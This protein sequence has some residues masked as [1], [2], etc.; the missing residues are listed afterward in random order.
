[1]AFAPQQ[2][3]DYRS[4]QGRVGKWFSLMSRTDGEEEFAIAGCI[5]FHRQTMRFALSSFWVASFQIVNE[6]SVG[7]IMGHCHVFHSVG[8]VH[9]NVLVFTKAERNGVRSLRPIRDA[10][11]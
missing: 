7:C 3:I 10:L 11:L 2:C 9:H 5:A 8:H 1:M 4:R 6:F